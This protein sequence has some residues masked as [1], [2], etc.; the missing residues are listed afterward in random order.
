MRTNHYGGVYP[1]GLEH[2]RKCSD[3]LHEWVVRR[4]RPCYETPITARAAEESVRGVLDPAA[5][6]QRD[7]RPGRQPRAKC[8]KSAAP[9]SGVQIAEKLPFA[10]VSY[11]GMT[12]VM[13]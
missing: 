8:G 4:F 9:R 10:M 1:P 11:Q 13:P 7:V 2:F 6:R 5:Q 3:G 12:S